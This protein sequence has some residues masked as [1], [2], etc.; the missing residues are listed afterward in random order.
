VGFDWSSSNLSV[1]E[2]SNSGWA[3]AMGGGNAWMT[4]YFEEVVWENNGSQCANQ[5]NTVPGYSDMEVLMPTAT[6]NTNTFKVSQVIGNQ[7][8]HHFV[9]PKGIANDLTLV[10]TSSNNSQQVLNNISWEG[11]TESANNPLEA[12]FIISNASKNVIRVKFYD[13]VLLEIRVWVVWATIGSSDIPNE[14]IFGSIGNPPGLGIALEGGYVFAHLISPSTIITDPDRPD[15]SG[16]RMNPPPGGNHPFNGGSLSGGADKKW[17][18]SRQIRIKVLNPNNISNNDITDPV[19]TNSLNYPAIDAEGNDDT[20]TG[21]NLTPPEE[22]ND[23][24]NNN[25]I[26]YGRDSPRIGLTH[27]S[28][29]NGNTFEVRIHF[30]EFTRLE[31]AGTWYRI[32]DFYL[33]R[34]HFKF[35]KNNGLWENDGSSK[36]LDNA[37]F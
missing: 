5:P 16:T 21:S 37:G 10:A 3:T 12:K 7:N 15:L 33:W 8:I 20:T 31:I 19:P 27:R 23:P 32:S 9:I 35:K 14:E 25:Q 24:Y 6:L 26:L 30:R 18:N 13:A 22:I 4:G 36:A 2:I 11:A 34:R 28:G 17:D 1:G 29:V